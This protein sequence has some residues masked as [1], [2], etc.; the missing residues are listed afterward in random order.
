MKALILISLFT[1]CGCTANKVLVDTKI[2]NIRFGGGGGFTGQITSYILNNK[3]ELTTADSLIVKLKKKE[4]EP[5]FLKAEA[6]IN[7]DYRKPENLYSFIE[8]SMPSDT[9]YIV[10]GF[11]DKDISAQA[12]ELHKDLS[13]LTNPNKKK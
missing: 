4:L 2:T 5:Y 8:L 3:G 13:T 1:I 6:L 7:Y 9:N 10:W 12:K 11:G